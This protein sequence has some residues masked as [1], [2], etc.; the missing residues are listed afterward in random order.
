MKL[1]TR[2]IA[3]SAITGAVY[4]VLTIALAPISY[5]YVQFR[6]S[7]VLC[8]LPYFIPGTAYGL[9]V[10]CLCANLITGNIFDIIFGSLATL[11]ACMLVAAIG[12]LQRTAFNAFCACMMPVIINALVIGAVITEAYNGL[13]IADNIQAFITYALWIA[14]GEGIVMLIPG[15]ILIRR[16]PKLKVFN[17]FVLSVE[18]N[19]ERSSAS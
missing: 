14:A 19:R 8:I 13:R 9:F 2:A 16:L 15:F 17:E 6:L 10:G 11:L 1:N 5:G 3:I 4:A 7:E 18:Q 12:R